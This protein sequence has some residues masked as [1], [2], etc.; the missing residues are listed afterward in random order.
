MVQTLERISGWAADVVLSLS[1]R[2]FLMWVGQGAAAAMLLG[3]QDSA[4]A[5]SCPTTET[6][7]YPQ[8]GVGPAESSYS[9]CVQSCT[10][11]NRAPLQSYCQQ[12]HTCSGDCPLGTHSNCVAEYNPPVHGQGPE[13]TVSAA[14]NPGL[15]CARGYVGCDFTVTFAVGQKVRCGC[16]CFNRKAIIETPTDKATPHP[17]YPLPT[18]GKV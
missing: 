18:R 9:I 6:S 17:H 7:D 16:T 2:K 1:R 12:F 3:I 4:Y 11:S 8:T 10:A 5:S 13:P 14:P 15:R